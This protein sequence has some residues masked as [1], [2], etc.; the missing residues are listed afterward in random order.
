MMTPLDGPYVQVGGKKMLDFSSHDFLGLGQH[1]EVRKSAIRYT[2]KYGIGTPS[3]DA[4]FA[5]QRELEE[6]LAHLLGIKEAAFFSNLEEARLRFTEKNPVDDSLAFGVLGN[7]GLGL[8][9]GQK[10]VIGTFSSI[11]AYT[12]STKG[13]KKGSYLPPPLLGAID[14][15]LCLA[16]EMEEERKNLKKHFQWLLG[17]LE[18]IGLSTPPSPLPRVFLPSSIA[19]LFAEEGIYVG[20]GAEAQVELCLTALHTPDDLDQ[21]AT[22]LKK[23]SATDLA[24]PM[25]SST[26]T[27]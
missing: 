17:R 6:K 23:F 25:Q 15:I 20:K 21:L 8:G 22:A 24:L 2:L 16:P 4:E 14:A 12:A 5:P 1:P 19:P 27:P 26:P 9:T 10:S 3:N 18:E 13:V 11:A 7:R